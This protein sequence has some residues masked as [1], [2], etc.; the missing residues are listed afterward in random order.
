LDTEEAE[1]IRERG[2]KTSGEVEEDYQDD[3][4]TSP[5]KSGG[6]GA[7]NVRAR[8]FSGLPEDELEDSC[9]EDGKRGGILVIL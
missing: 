5:N 6:D 3:D 4:D 1:E 7:R 9:D 8:L 2:T